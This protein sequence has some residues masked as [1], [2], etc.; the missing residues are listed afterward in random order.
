MRESNASNGSSPIP[1]LLGTLTRLERAH[2]RLGMLIDRH[3]QAV[4]KADLNTMRA[5]QE[6]ARELAE[7]I[8]QHDQARQRQ[9]DSIARSHGLAVLRNK[10]ISL[11]ELADLLDGND[12]RALRTARDR[13]RSV[14]GVTA[15]L[16]RV[17]TVTTRDLLGHLSAVLSSV[18]PAAARVDTYGQSGAVAAGSAPQLVD[19]LG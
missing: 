7:S 16:Q 18:R 2:E 13:L 1:E 9:M 14:G 19:A 5:T 4:R 17:A 3:L 6:E 10:R 15:R 8:T 12:A 11:S